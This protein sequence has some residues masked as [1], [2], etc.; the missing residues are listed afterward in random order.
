MEIDT[1]NMAHLGARAFKSAAKSCNDGVCYAES[2]C[3]RIQGHVCAAD[4]ADHARR[5]GRDVLGGQ[6]RF[7]ARQDNFEK[8]PGAPVAYWVSEKLLDDFDNGKALSDYAIPR[9]GIMTGDN[10]EVFTNLVEK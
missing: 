1:V 9:T 8:I 6:N 3:S 10:G 4:R 5:K 7:S 2:A